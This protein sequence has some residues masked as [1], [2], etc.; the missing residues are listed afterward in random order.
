[1]KYLVCLSTFFVLALTATSQTDFEDYNFESLTNDSALIRPAWVVYEPMS[2]FYYDSLVSLLY[3]GWDVFENW[4]GYNPW[5]GLDFSASCSQG[6]NPEEW[7]NFGP[8]MELVFS[9]SL[10]M[11]EPIELSIPQ[12]GG[13]MYE[14][15]DF[16][17]LPLIDPTGPKTGCIIVPEASVGYNGNWLISTFTR[18]C[19]PYTGFN[20]WMQYDCGPVG[21]ER[22][23]YIPSGLSIPEGWYKLF[24][25]LSGTWATNGSTTNTDYY[26]NFSWTCDGCAGCTDPTACNFYEYEY[27]DNSTCNYITCNLGCVDPIAC[28]FNMD[29][30]ID[31]GSCTYP[32]PGYLCDGTAAYTLCGEGT[33]WSDDEKQCV[34]ISESCTGDIDFDGLVSINDLLILLS[35]FGESCDDSTFSSGEWF[36]YIFAEPQSSEYDSS[37]LDFAIENGAEEWYS[38]WS[39]TAPND[40]GG[41]YSHDLNIYAHQPNFVNGGDGLVTPSDLSGLIDSETKLFDQITVSPL[42]VNTDIRYFY[43]IWLP[44][45]GMGGSL[46][47]YQISVGTESSCSS[48]FGSIPAI[49]PYQNSFDVIV[50]GGAAIPEGHYRVLWITPEMNLPASLP[51]VSSICIQGVGF[52]D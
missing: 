22:S 1:M 11:P 28:N 16:E 20:A 5:L 4:E 36:A 8:W 18:N 10:P 37:F 40:N 13:G 17:V 15:Q 38:Y 49:A 35:A 41:N 48:T 42:E 34:L 14:I 44:V 21:H 12:S 7:D 24:F 52:V 46:S 23:A 9:G 43:S 3:G 51:M 39:G 25:I 31:D 19:H 30:S 32:D 6:A 26:S 47:S 2:G 29:A 27:S 50:T 33:I 45:D